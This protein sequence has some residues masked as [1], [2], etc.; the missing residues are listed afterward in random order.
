[1][2]FLF[3]VLAASL[4]GWLLSLWRVGLFRHRLV[5]GCRLPTHQEID[6]GG[7]GSA[8]LAVCVALIKFNLGVVGGNVRCRS[9]IVECVMRFT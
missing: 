5:G 4:D 8:V 2:G 1:M 6:S 9:V 7:S 3:R